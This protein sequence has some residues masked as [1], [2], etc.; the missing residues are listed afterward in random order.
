MTVVRRPRREVVLIN[1]AFGVGKSTVARQLH[2]RLEGSRQFDPEQIGYVLRRLPAAVPFSSAHLDDYRESATWRAL[3][4]RV[5]SA[6]SWIA[7]PLIVPMALDITHLQLIRSGLADR[8]CRVIHVCLVASEQVVHG[9]LA[10]RGVS[11]SSAEGQWVY[12]RALAA[13]RAHVDAQ[14]ARHI[15]TDAATPPEIVERIIAIL[16]ECG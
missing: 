1:G 9:R 2:A 6:L 5:A 7:R 16:R 12:P 3:T 10:G 15:D 11:P 8:G 4:T 13:C 14:Y